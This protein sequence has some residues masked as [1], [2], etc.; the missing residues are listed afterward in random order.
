MELILVIYV[1]DT[2]KE[3][4]IC[5]AQSLKLLSRSHTQ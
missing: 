5:L 3:N 1:G 2:I 4:Y